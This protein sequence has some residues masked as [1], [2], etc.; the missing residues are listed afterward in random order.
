MAVGN[1]I[2]CIGMCCDATS[3]FGLLHGWPPDGINGPHFVF[4]HNYDFC[5]DSAEPEGGS[6]VSLKLGWTF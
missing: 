5:N 2:T 4:S 6:R 1:R 3:V